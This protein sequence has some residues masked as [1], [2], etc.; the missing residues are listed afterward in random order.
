MSVTPASPSRASTSRMDSARS[1]DWTRPADC[2]PFAR[3]PFERSGGAERVAEI[4][5][6]S[7]AMGA[8]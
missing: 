4:E 3:S 1:T 2:S 7:V 8:Q 6:A 5:A